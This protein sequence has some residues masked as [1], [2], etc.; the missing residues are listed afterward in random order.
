MANLE[1]TRLIPLTQGKFAI[2]DAEDFEWLNQWRWYVKKGWSTFYVARNKWVAKGKKCTIRIH[3]EILNPNQ[4][5]E[6]D[7]IN[8]NGLDNRRCN[9][10][11]V[12]KSQNQMNH[13]KYRKSSSKHKGV[14]FHKP[15]SKWQV[16]ISIRKTRK[17][18][19]LFES[20]IK[21][22]QSY[23]EAVK[24]YFGEFAR[25]NII[26]EVPEEYSN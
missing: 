5:Q 15:T 16:S 3:R 17:Y 18:I 1:N 22:A 24:R 11:A 4:M 23:N 14:S 26:E 10:R 13:G 8:G 21:A 2:V 7:H 20:E 19:G 25:L 9:L 6:V 12:D